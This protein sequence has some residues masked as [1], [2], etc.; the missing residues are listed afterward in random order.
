MKHV[1][2]L[3]PVSAYDIQGLESWLE[4]MAR[5]GLRLIRLR[6]SFSTFAKGPGQS[7]RYR[8]EPCKKIIDGDV[9]QA[10][11]D[12]YQ[13][14]GWDYICTVNSELLVFSTQDPDAPEPHSDPE[15]QGKLW[16]RLYRSKRRGFWFSLLLDLIIAGF[17]LWTLFQGGTPV[18]NLLTTSVLITFTLL[19]VLLF[20]LPK[21]WADVQ[22]LSLIAR[23]LEEGVPL[24]HRSFYPRRRWSEVTLLA[25]AVFLL[26]GLVFSQNI[27]PFTGGSVHPLEELSAFTPLSLA[28]LEGEAYTP[29]SFV[30]DG[31]DYANFCVLDHYLLCRDRWEVLQT[32]KTGPD[33]LARLRIW[34]YDL[35]GWLSGLSVPLAREL[36]E[37]HMDLM[38]PTY[39]SKRPGPVWTVEYFNN[40][41]AVFL[42]AAHQRDGQ[43]HLAA[44]ACGDKVVLV[45]YTG[46]SDL[47]RPKHLKAIADMVS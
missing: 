2:K 22:R 9:P 1:C 43:Y 27:L 16:N 17:A 40:Y 39:Y 14:F 28:E 8:V 24:N 6:P 18:L 12:L 38:D 33:D 25:L 11:L 32:C 5:R 31:R 34:R 44:A 41:D 37:Q 26:A 19:A 21:S 47:T 35:P 20:E 42:A 13:D 46:Q 7:L 3:T 10:M 15:L 45:Q 23:Q 29:D 36:L 30:V 4:D